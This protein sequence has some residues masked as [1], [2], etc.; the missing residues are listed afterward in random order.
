MAHQLI[1]LLGYVVGPEF[2]YGVLTILA[3]LLLIYSINEFSEIINLPSSI[4][5]YCV[6][7]SPA[8]YLFTYIFGQLPGFLSSSLF[9][10][11]ISRL[12]RGGDSDQ[13][14]PIIESG[15]LISL[16]F[17]SH[18]LAP[19]LM[20]PVLLVGV[21]KDLSLRSFIRPLLAIAIAG[22]I[23]APIAYE[24]SIFM[25]STPSQV[26][27][28]HPTR[29]NILLSQYSLTFFWG[30]YGPVAVF[31][32]LG[33]AVYARQHQYYLLL[34]SLGYMVLG[35]GGTTPIPKLLLGEYFYNW[36]TYEKF[37]LWAMLLLLIPV[38]YYIEREYIPRVAK[39]L[40]G[41]GGSIVKASVIFSFIFS[42][43]LL[44]Y[45]SS[46]V[47]PTQPPKPDI[48]AI[49]EFLDSRSGMGFYITLGLG[50]WSRALALETSKPYLD[51]GF[52]SA[53]RLPILASSGVESIDNAKYFPNGTGLVEELLYNDYGVKWVVLGDEYYRP[54]LEEAGYKLVGTV[55]GSLNVSIWENL[56]MNG[57][58]KYYLDMDRPSIAWA[59]EPPLILAAYISLGIWRKLKH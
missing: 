15:L 6:A 43:L 35:L 23:V 31:I 18:Y 20:T 19:L 2:A 57:Y 38:T 36:L 45:I 21:F 24:L 27:I 7:F 5:G 46:F 3:I 10:L 26:T 4:L 42:T 59:L 11:A 41:Y 39:G 13:L 1:A 25:S 8:V 40:R 49:A 53:R 48:D 44:L 9:L 58:E 34:V 33:L 54:I 55:N 12:Y 16:A 52:N 17:M 22:L 30:I 56:S 51:G 37:A 14:W 50:V 47:I 28:W 29:E 32:P